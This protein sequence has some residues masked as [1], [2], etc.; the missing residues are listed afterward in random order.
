MSSMSV[1]FMRKP[2]KGL[3]DKL[4]VDGKEGKARTKLKL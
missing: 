3:R 1:L 2:V 4:L